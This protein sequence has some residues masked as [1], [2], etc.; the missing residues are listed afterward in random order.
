MKLSA[1]FLL[2]ALLRECIA[3]TALSDTSLRAL[4]PA[5][6]SDFNIKDGK[7][8][9]PILIPRV[10][11]TPGSEKVLKHFIDFF[12]NNLPEWRLSFQ[13]SSS[14]TPTSHGKEIPF[15]NLIATRDPPWILDGHEG[16]VGRLALV[17][18]YDSKLT[19][20]GFIGATDSAAPCAMLLHVAQSLDASLTKKWA[21]MEA[22]G[23][24]SG[25]E[26]HKGLQIILLDG[27]EAFQTWTHTDSLYGAR[28]LAEEWEDTMHPAMSTYKNPL[29]SIDLFVLLDLL[30]S[31]EPTVPSYFRTTHWAYQ[32]LASVEERLRAAKVLASSPKKSF[33]PEAEKDESCRWLGGYIEDDH[34]PFMARGVEILHLIASPFPHVWHTKDD[35][36]EHL[37]IPTVQDWAV[38][39]AGFAAEWMDLE[40]FLES[41]SERRWEEE[42][43]EL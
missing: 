42:K 28:A 6:D 21:S 23:A 38:I 41:K 11:G 14:T 15:V 36:G 8:L 4:P 22:E 35:D 18:H 39:T 43:S 19:P 31:A 1:F 37:D 27:E 33:L 5:T 24:G 29:D 34:L 7:L 3:Y 12:T 30:G 2:P 20:T 40:G 32:L 26:D 13:N 17:A 16:E 10:P 25:L 9:A